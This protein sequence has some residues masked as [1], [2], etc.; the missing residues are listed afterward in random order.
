VF[1]SPILDVL[2]GAVITLDIKFPVAWAD[3]VVV[4]NVPT[5]SPSLVCG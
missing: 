1:D 5:I 4:L 3:T 2:D